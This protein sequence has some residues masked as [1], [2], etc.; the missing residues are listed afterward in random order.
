MPRV[1]CTDM[2]ESLMTLSDR[3]IGMIP[4]LS[5]FPNER[6]QYAL[7]EHEGGWDWFLG[8]LREQEVPS[9]RLRKTM[10]AFD[11]IERCEE[12]REEESARRDSK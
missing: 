9:D 2:R 1:R 10:M 5:A 11:F 6:I 7:T 12:Y 4:A 8:P 3:M